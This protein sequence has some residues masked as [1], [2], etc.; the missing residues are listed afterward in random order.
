MKKLV[1]LF[2]FFSLSLFSQDSLKVTTDTIKVAVDTTYW[3]HKNEIG[4]DLTQV[5]FINWSIGGENSISGLLKGRFER[6]YEK[7]MLSWNNDLTIRYG[8]NKQDDREMRKTDD[9]FQFVS[10]VGYKFRKKSKWSYSSKLN[11]NTQFTNG[12]AYPDKDVAISHAFAPAYIFLG[13]GTEFFEKRKVKSE[14]IIFYASPLTVK[15]TMVFNQRLAD[16]GAFGVE[17]AV[18]DEEGNRL[19]KGKL[20][21]TE[22]GILL[23]SGWKKEI[24]ENINFESRIT[25]FTDYYNR[26]GNIDLNWQMQLDFVVNKHVR[27]NISA[28][29]IYDDDIKAKEKVGDTM[30]TVGPKLQVKQAIGIGLVYAW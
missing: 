23:S 27:A 14:E 10:T 22:V 12:Y 29:F 9:I 13:V 2:L 15:S 8:I 26:F 17:K 5:A 28:H 20:H 21:K 4:L 11:F 18:Y 1:V 24:Y 25:L 3:T 19:S 16:Q 30:L 7:E 6:R